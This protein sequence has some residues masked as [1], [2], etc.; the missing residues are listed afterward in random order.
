MK[1]ILLILL[2][3]FFGAGINAQRAKIETKLVTP[4]MLKEHAEFTADS[5]V[6]S[7]LSNV[8]NKTWC[9][10]NV[11]NISGTAAITGATWTLLANRPAQTLQLLQ[12]AASSGGLS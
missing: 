8:A 12:S 11:K 6:A 3:L 9:Y 4:E 10:V 2:V 7:G 5:T 1:K